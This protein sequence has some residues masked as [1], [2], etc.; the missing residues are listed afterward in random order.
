MKL[1]KLFAIIGVFFLAITA[2]AVIGDTT[3]KTNPKTTPFTVKSDDERIKNLETSVK[4]LKTAVSNIQSTL[5]ELQD[6]LSVIED[7]LAKLKKLASE[8]K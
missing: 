2:I 4:E 5:K 8:K 3:Y 6:K 1:N 7:K